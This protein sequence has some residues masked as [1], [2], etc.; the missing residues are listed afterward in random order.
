RVAHRGRKGGDEYAV[1]RVIAGD[2]DQVALDAGRR[3]NVVRL[4]VA[5]ERVDEQT[6]DGLEC[7]LRQV[8]VRAVDRIARLEADDALPAAVRERSTRL[9]GIA[10]Q[11]RKGGPRPL[12]HRHLAREVE[13]LLSVET[14]DTGVCV[15]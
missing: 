8:L 3:R 13:R 1:G 12:K 5:D 11:L 14:R 7:D 9:G 15:V 10:R 6:V 4:G 2:E